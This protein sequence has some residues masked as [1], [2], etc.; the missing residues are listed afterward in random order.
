MNMMKLFVLM[1]VVALAIWARQSGFFEHTL[2]AF[3]SLGFWTAPAFVML[4]TLS[5]ILLFPSMILTCCAGVL[6]PLPL[7]ILLSLLGTMLGSV[8][9]L[10]IGRYGLRSFIQKKAAG[11]PKF[12]RLDEALQR[13]GWKIVVMARLT[14]IFPFSVG[15]YL[16]G[17]TKISAW[18][19]AGTAFVGT[20]PSAFVYA[21]AGYMA[22]VD[23]ATPPAKTAAEWVLLAGG[24]VITVFL[25]WYLGR[26]FKRI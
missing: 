9:A 2:N 13:E 4:Y 20:I 26:F 24:A 19:Y 14:P 16:F 22:G 11:D 23:Q 17:A 1:L 6:F 8:A 3:K 21:I 15:N 25:S 7:A 18:V 5:C 12:R 10:L